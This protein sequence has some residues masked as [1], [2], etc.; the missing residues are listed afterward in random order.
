[1]KLSVAFLLLTTLC[2]TVQSVEP[3]GQTG[4]YD[5]NPDHLWNRLH[6]ALFLREDKDGIE[7]GYDD[8]VPFNRRDSE[9]FLAGEP[10][11]K[12]LALLDEFLSTHG[13]KL[14][15]DPI[16]RAVLQHDLWAVFDTVP[17]L[18]GVR[19]EVRS[20]IEHNQRAL[21]IRLA[22]CIQRL[23]LRE[24]EIKALPDN[25]AQAIKS[26]AF[27]AKQDP[28]HPETAFLPPDLFDPKGSW[29]E[30]DTSRIVGEGEAVT[31][32]VHVE[33]ASGRSA[34]QVF[35]RL[36]GGR[37][38]TL[39]YLNKL[40]LFTTP[41]KFQ[42][43]P[44]TTYKLTEPHETLAA[45][46]ETNNKYFAPPERGDT[47]QLNPD[48]PQF[49]TGTTVAL[50][51]R[52]IL[53]SD[54]IEPVATPL[55]ESVQMRVYRKVPATYE[56][57]DVDFYEIVLRRVN[58]FAGQAGGLH[59]LEKNEKEPNLLNMGVGRA[60]TEQ[61]CYI[62]HSA[63]GIFSVKSYTRDLA[64]MLPNPQ[65]PPETYPDAAQSAVVYWK[66]RQFDWGLLTGLLD[67]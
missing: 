21:A 14:V 56:D 35:I 47:L 25:F 60:T 15:R 6:R 16:K 37:E 45:T 23:A 41:W 50:V 64:P 59:A 36:P 40:N 27:A 20:E 55:I 9:A 11:R 28:E 3:G 13:E 51:R 48:T 31:A 42:P 29:V 19:G 44:L 52:M 34:F 61:S 10:Y 43:A 18:W 5:A 22:R 53:V 26:G 8:T 2:V 46:P 67:H 62:C 24:E 33:S 32:P 65:L 66:K 30:I 58:L 4:L 63:S 1:M 49:P 12:A 38:Q 57:H 7:Y 17:T 39:A 54:K